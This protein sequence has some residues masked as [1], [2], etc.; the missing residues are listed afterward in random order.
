MVPRRI[1]PALL[2]FAALAGCRAF[3]PGGL[4]QRAPLAPPQQ[5]LAVAQFV[6]RHNQ[7]AEQL[8][9]LQ[10]ATNVSTHDGTGR[11]FVALE[12]PR[13]FRLQLKSVRSPVADIGSNG[14]E[15]WVWTTGPDKNRIYVCQYDENGETPP[16]LELTFQPEWIVEGLGLRVIS[17]AEEKQLTTER[18]SDPNYVVLVHH[19]PSN[20]GTTGLKKT[21]VAR[22]GEIREHWFYGSDGKPVARVVASDYRRLPLGGSDAGGAAVSL[23]QKITL[24][25][26]PP[27]QKPFEMAI[28]LSDFR[29]N[30]SFPEATQVFSMP[31]IPGTKVVNIN[32]GLQPS[33]GPTTVRETRPIP[34]SGLRVRIGDPVPLSADG[35]TRNDNDPAP[36]DADLRSSAGGI[37]ALVRS[38][39]PAPP[40]DP[41][42]ADQVRDANR[43]HPGP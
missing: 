3:E 37:S 42:L 39:Y 4:S 20:R 43:F 2:A 13:N 9:G 27:G 32:D 40:D 16:E 34:E 36:L 12:R 19:R 38:H 18:A 29:V 35:L 31:E 14:D 8:T 10:A 23:P 26:M 6:E 30:P 7:N 25:S 15:F 21:V 17:E 22:T 5:S 24:V 28:K 33:R 1:L 11:G 41:A